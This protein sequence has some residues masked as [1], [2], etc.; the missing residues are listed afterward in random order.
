MQ[1]IVRERA[2]ARDLG[3]YD[4]LVWGGGLSGWAAAVRLAR[5]GHEVLLAAPRTSLGYEV[6]AAMGTWWPPELEAP[7]LWTEITNEVERVGAA[8]GPLVDAVA[9]QVALERAAEQAGVEMLMQV[10][11]HPG[12]EDRTL[13]T[14]RWGLMAARSRVV[15]D[16]GSRGALA[17]EA[18]ARARVRETDEPV[19]RR[20][21]MVKTGVTE[22][23]RIEVGEDLSLRDGTVMAWTGLWP[24]DVVLHAELDLPTGD[25][26]ALEMRSRRTMAEIAIRLRRTREDFGQGSLVSIAHEAIL[27]RK[28]VLE[29]SGDGTVVAEIRG[30]DGALDVTRGM[31]LP[32]GAG[33]VI[34]ASPALDC[35]D[36]SAQSCHH[37]PNA[38]AVGE[39]AAE[40]ADEM[41]RTG[42]AGDA[43]ASD[44]RGA[45]CARADRRR[46]GVAAGGR[47]WRG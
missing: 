21:L 5:T 1:Q 11:A 34:V 31:M 37:A 46:R 45:G 8:R 24:G 10:N 39:G 19:I 25:M 28:R 12:N 33:G 23:E 22:P 44:T 29:A 38:V 3:S 17:V 18:G 30:E 32:E 13:L 20:A 15:I 16:G 4:A 35:G 2:V 7:E 41:P 43:R 14:G 27:P 42:S 6:W 40:I 26:T 36:I 47:G 9:T